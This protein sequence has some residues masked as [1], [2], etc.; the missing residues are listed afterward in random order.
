LGY[1]L[2]DAKGFM[3]WYAGTTT[4][5][6][7]DI[8]GNLRGSTTVGSDNNMVR[9]GP[10]ADPNWYGW[11]F[12]GNPYTSA[13][14]WDAGTGWTKTNISGTIYLYNNGNWNTWNG[15]TGTVMT[16]GHIAMGQGF[17]VE[18][19]N[20]GSTLG[21]LKM[22]ND[23]QTHNDVDFL[24]EGAKVV[25]ELVR[26]Q[27]SNEIFTDETVIYF[28]A[29]ATDGFDSQ[30]DA[31]KLFSFDQT[32]P[33]IY[34]T[35]NNKMAIN[36]LPIENTEV[37]VDVSGVD[38]EFMTIESTEILGFGDV[39]MLDNYTGMQTNLSEASYTF[40]YDEDVSNRFL[41]FFTTVSTPE[42][43]DE[44][45]TIYSFDNNVR[46]I[47]PEETQANIVIYNLVGQKLST[48][49]AHKG[50]VDIP[51]YETGYYL[52]KVMDNNNIVTKKVFIK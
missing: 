29:D 30:F 5:E 22:T 14:D 36:V 48:T 33:H 28:D 39:F 50:V 20:D 40:M 4:G 45:V 47:V 18:V 2:G 49:S 8:T 23:V 16:S 25:D 12:V 32:R 35:A 17:F 52:V 3:M 44:F 37:L 13:I 19:N 42:I 6:T 9:T 41:I 26:L 24:K 7:F 1:N 15:T 10:N 46:V 21:T 34:S 38:G 43:S 31:H 27:V 11:N 51:V